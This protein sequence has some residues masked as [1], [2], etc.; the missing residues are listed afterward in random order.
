MDH[1]LVFIRRNLGLPS[2]KNI[3]PGLCNYP[4]HVVNIDSHG[5]VFVCFCEAWLPWSLGHVMDF[6]SIADIWQHPLKKT[7]EHSQRQGEYAYCDTVHCGVTQSP[8]RLCSLQI[9]IGIDD[10]CQLTCPSCRLEPVF[11]KEFDIKL[12]WVQRIVQWINKLESPLPIDILIGSHGDPFASRLYRGLMTYLALLKVPV[13]FQLRTNG[14]L[15]SRYLDELQILPRLSKLEISIDAAEAYTY[16]Q[17]RRPGKW[18]SLI[19]N[20]DYCLSIRTNKNP[21]RVLANFV[22]QKANY[23]EMPAFVE[24]CSKYHMFPNFTVLQDWSTFSYKDNAV[25]LSDHPCYQEFV[26]VVNDSLVKKT[27]GKTLDH[28][29]KR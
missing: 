8:R 25:H 15:L 23:R 6:E 14:L 1:D 3:T 16:E 26:Q 20:L 9:Y 24:L 27:I 29:I 18:Q 17:V 22:I 10:S 4:S 2:T 7:I 5:R 21:F 28:W 13:R 11:E 19:E 12:P